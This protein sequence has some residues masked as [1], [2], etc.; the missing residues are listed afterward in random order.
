MLYAKMLEEL[1]SG[2]ATESGDGAFCPKQSHEAVE[3]AGELDELEEEV[4]LFA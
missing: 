2:A 3:R 4:C 1:V